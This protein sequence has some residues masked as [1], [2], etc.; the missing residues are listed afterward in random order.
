MPT[1]ITNNPQKQMPQKG[2]AAIPRFFFN[3][4]I[5]LPVYVCLFLPATIAWNVIAY[6]FK[7]KPN[8]NKIAIQQENLDAAID[9]KFGIYEVKDLNS[10]Q[11]DLVLFGAT[12]Y[13]GQLAAKYLA[14][15]YGT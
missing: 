4:F 6:P 1:A 8:T 2:T 10:R 3:F 12:G 15:Q 14:D 13:T 7:R 5:A 9:K 11:F